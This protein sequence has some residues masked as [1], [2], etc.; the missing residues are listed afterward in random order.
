MRKITFHPGST[1]VGRILMRQSADQIKEVPRWNWAANAPFIVFDDADLDAPPS[2]GAMISNG[3]HTNGYSTTARDI[4]VCAKPHPSVQAGVYD[5][6]ADN[7]S[8]AA[9]TRPEMRLRR[10]LLGDRL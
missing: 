4:C 2:M 8:T 1:E 10:R 9:G 5:A 6:F 3:Q 7:S